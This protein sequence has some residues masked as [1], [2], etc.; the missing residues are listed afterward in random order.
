MA[1][2]TYVA[3]DTKVLG[4]AATSV[5][6]TSIPQGYTDLVLV[7]TV[8]ATSGSPENLLFQLNSDTGANYSNTWLSG[9][10]STATSARLSNRNFGYFGYYAY[11]PIGSNYNNII[12]HFMNYSNATTNKTSLSRSNSAATGTDASVSLWR[13]TAAVTSLKLFFATNTIAV[14]STFTLYGIAAAV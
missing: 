8:Q 14:G 4:T 2:N 5:T 6:F 9:D 1:S 7:A 13:S 11:P 10:G 12:G 3:L